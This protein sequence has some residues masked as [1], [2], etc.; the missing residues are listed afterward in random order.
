MLTSEEVQ[1]CPIP[2]HPYAIC[3]VYPKA[4]YTVHNIFIG[5]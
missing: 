5:M 3:E 2:R 1:G 4:G